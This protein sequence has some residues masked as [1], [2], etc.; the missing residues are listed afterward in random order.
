MNSLSPVEEIKGRLDIVDLI[1]EY[2][3][4]KVA[5]MN[6]KAKCPFHNEKTPSFM[7]SRDRGTW[8]C[9]GCARGGDIFS[10]V[11]EMEGTDF[12]ETLRTLAKRAGV[13]LR[14]VDPKLQTQKTKALDA[15][16]WVSR[17]WHE[18]LLKSSEAKDARD[19]LNSRGIK[20][21]TIE[22]FMIGYAVGSGEATHQA[23]RKKGFSD[24]DIFQ[25]GL[26]IK[27]DRGVGFFD[28]FRHR[29]MFPINDVQGN[30]VGFSGRILESKLEANKP[31]PAKYINTPQ[32]LV[33]NKS[34]VLYAL[35]K[36]K[37]A[38]KS[39]DRAVLV[40]GQMDCISSHQA[41]VRNVV[42]ATGTALTTEQVKLLKRYSNTVAL[43]FDRDTAGAQATIR[44]VEQALRAQMNVRIIRLPFGKDPD[45][46]I[47]RDVAAWSKAVQDA[48]PIMDYF[49]TQATAGK[50]LH[51]IDHKKTV[52]RFLL[53]IIAKVG[54]QIEQTHYLQ[55]LGDLIRVD[56]QSLRRSLPSERSAAQQPAGEKPPP[57]PPA[58]DRYHQVSER[59]LA[60]LIKEPRFI[61]QTSG[62]IDPELFIG[63]D[64][65]ALYKTIVLWYTQ[66]QLQQRHDLA[67][68]LP[69]VETEQQERFTILN[70]LADREFPEDISSASLENELLTM[71]ATLK[72]HRLS[73]RLRQL[74]ADLR[75]L[76]Q[77]PNS[78]T[79]SLT[80]LLDE[81]RAV[82]EQMRDL[83]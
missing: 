14:Q 57:P 83:T 30:V 79:A 32:T 80:P 73:S 39:A 70:L 29:I 31:V 45:E 82:T 9:F 63:D 77:D 24:D 74:E 23:L 28:R 81:V 33:Y 5:G 53:P 44:G 36:A 11:Q 66:Q 65:M 54:D 18:V 58:P 7:V 52:A 3:P 10:F 2:V 69:S 12:P 21:E 48:E 6:W 50:D 20:L 75:H 19:Y 13:Q 46:V 78:T 25:A 17:Y 61:G 47:K 59:L 38:I 76:E 22:D 71:V 72:K 51:N 40:E 55:R 42:G 64:Y 26:T 1:G 43:A 56:E 37:R 8:H 67:D 68:L 60:L 16:R 35:D 15:L 62:Q 34:G 41:E 49:F 27:K 4:L